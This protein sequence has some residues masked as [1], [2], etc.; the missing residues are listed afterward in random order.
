VQPLTRA[1]QA[2]L[3]LYE[4]CNFTSTTTVTLSGTGD[5]SSDSPPSTTQ[6][7]AMPT[8]TMP[9]PATTES[10]E[11]QQSDSY[12]S[13]NGACERCAGVCA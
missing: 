4:S 12:V 5:V 11:D 8:T 2:D 9:T 13:L 3:N 1:A 10:V 7:T 6:G